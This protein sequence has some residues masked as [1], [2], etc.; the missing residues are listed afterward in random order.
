MEKLYAIKRKNGTIIPDSCSNSV[1]DSWLYA[2]EVEFAGEW[3]D[4]NAEQGMRLTGPAV[5]HAE[6]GESLGYRCVDVEIVEKGAAE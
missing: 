1:R 6:C 4:A 2:C 5:S 3:D